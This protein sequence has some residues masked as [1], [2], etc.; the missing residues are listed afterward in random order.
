MNLKKLFCGKKE[1]VVCV[2]SIGSSSVGGILILNR[3][4]RNGEEYKPEILVSVRV[5]I[6]FLMKINYSSFLK[7]AS[8]SVD[9]VLKQLLKEHPKGVDKVFCFFSSP[10][11]VSQARIISVKRKEVFNIDKS[12]LDELIQREKKIFYSQ[13]RSRQKISRGEPEFIESEMIRVDLNGY[14]VNRLLGKKART[15]EMY[16]YMSLGIKKLNEFVR[17]IVLKNFGSVDLIFNTLPYASFSVFRDTLNINTE[18]GFIFVDFGG[19]VSDISLVRRGVLEEVISFPCGKNSIFRK[20]AEE[21]KVSISEARSLLKIFE[22][23]DMKQ[24]DAVK[25]SSII[26]LIREDWQRCLSDALIEIAHNEPLPQSLF[27]ISNKKMDSSLINYLSGESLSGFTILGKPFAV[28]HVFPQGLKDYFSLAKISEED[29]D[30]FLMIESL[31]TVNT[32]HV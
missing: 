20:I 24:P 27:F 12:F 18:D 13:W 32:K 16:V 8:N 15:L 23:K 5:P 1:E 26:D 28:S 14:R 2:L 3:N 19:E 31:F 29:K 11:F 10:W 7:F 25:I 6:N 9:D 22:S 4:E 30:V 21:F 17:E